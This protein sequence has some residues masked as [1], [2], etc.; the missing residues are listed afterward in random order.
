MAF[1]VEQFVGDRA[2]QLGLEEVIRPLS[3]GTDWQRIRFGITCAYNTLFTVSGAYLGPIMGLCTGYTGRLSAVATD[4]IFSNFV[5]NQTLNYAG[6][7]PNFYLDPSVT[8]QNYSYQRVGAAQGNSAGFT[9]G[10]YCVSANPTAMRTFFAV[11]ITKGTVGTASY[12]LTQYAPINT[13][14]VNDFSYATFL[15][16]M[17]TDGTPANT[18]PLTQASAYCGLRT[19]KDW[20]CV[21]L[22]HS[23]NVP[24]LTVFNMAV[25][26]YS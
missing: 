4:I 8:L 17:T 20:N 22:M 13:Q 25:T 5:T 1:I 9:M 24:A 10:R 18:S 23:R 21:Y 3:F 11:D 16:A 6:A 14:I 26:R 2:L 12:S 7:G 19:V 15:A